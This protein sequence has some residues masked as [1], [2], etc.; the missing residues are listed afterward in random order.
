MFPAF[1]L[2]GRHDESRPYAAAVD[3]ERQQTLVNELRYIFLTN[4]YHTPGAI[5]IFTR[6]TF[7]YANGAWA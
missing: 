5:Y 2:C 7:T 1:N 3:S 6:F 4:E